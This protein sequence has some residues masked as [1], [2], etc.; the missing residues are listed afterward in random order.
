MVALLST[1]PGVSVAHVDQGAFG[2]VSKKPTFLMGLNTPTLPF[3]MSLVEGSGIM[4]HKHSH[5]LKG[6]NNDAIHS[7]CSL[8]MRAVLMRAIKNNSVSLYTKY[9]RHSVCL[10]LWKVVMLMRF[11]MLCCHESSRA[12]GQPF[13][14]DQ[15]PFYLPAT[16]NSWWRATARNRD[17]PV[18]TD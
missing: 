2:A 9:V 15:K 6:K 3:R 13:Y 17:V 18:R 4:R 1:L 12:N 11:F 8:F 7:G 16:K 5:T 14:S 10:Q